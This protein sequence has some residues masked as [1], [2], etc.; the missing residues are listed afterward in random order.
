[1]FSKKK[2]MLEQKTKIT[3]A[4]FSLCMC[5]GVKRFHP[6]MKAGNKIQVDHVS[7]RNFVA[8]TCNSFSS[9]NACADPANAP[10]PLENHKVVGFLMNTGQYPLPVINHKAI[11]KEGCKDQESIQQTHSYTPQMRT[12][13]P[14]LSQ[15]VTTRHI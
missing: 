4:H 12:K 11:R 5:R 7:C 14:A 10:P 1:M 13:R 2:Y 9:L 8:K 3:I 6:D 15:Q